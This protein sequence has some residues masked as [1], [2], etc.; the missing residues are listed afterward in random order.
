MVRG[1]LV[2]FERGERVRDVEDGLGFEVDFNILMVVVGRFVYIP[3]ASQW[4]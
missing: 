4:E 3:R 1:G 2:E